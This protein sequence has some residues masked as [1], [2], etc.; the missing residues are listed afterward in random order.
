MK[1]LP[2]GLRLGIF[3]RCIFKS[4]Q[5]ESQLTAQKLT[6]LAVTG[7][8]TCSLLCPPP[9]DSEHLREHDNNRSTR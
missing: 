9:D 1:I 4:D 5:M 7:Q 3:L 2:S 6:E 8:N